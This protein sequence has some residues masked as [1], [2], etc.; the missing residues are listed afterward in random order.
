MK[1]SKILIALLAGVAVGLLMAPHSGAKTRKKIM[2]R[3]KNFI[4]DVQDK[5]Y[6]AGENIKNSYQSVKNNLTKSI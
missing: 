3:G 6:H 4:D 1:S 5:A 2:K